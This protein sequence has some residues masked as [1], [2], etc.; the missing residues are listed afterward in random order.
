MSESWLRGSFSITGY[1]YL[2][3]KGLCSAGRHLT[4][5]SADTEKD[6]FT[7]LWEEFSKK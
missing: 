2:C 5:I 1:Y 7:V 6:I 4:G 3:G